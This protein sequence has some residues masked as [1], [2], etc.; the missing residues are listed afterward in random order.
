MKQTL[1]DKLQLCRSVLEARTIT[2]DEPGTILRDVEIVLEVIGEGVQVGGKNAN[3]PPAMLPHLNQRMA[4]PIELKLRRA[5]LR[6]YPNVAGVYILLRTLGLVVPE[7]KKVRVDPERLSTWNAMNPVEKYFSLLEC[8][9]IYAQAG[10]LGGEVSRDSDNQLMKHVPTILLAPLKTWK[11]TFRVGNAGWRLRLEDAWSFQLMARFGL[12]VTR[13]DRGE[14]QEPSSRGWFP[15]EMKATEWG[16]AVA[17]RLIQNTLEIL[18]EAD[19]IV[20]G[21]HLAMGLDESA[22]ERVVERAF[23][24]FFPDLR[25]WLRPPSVHFCEGRY[26]FKI[27]LRGHDQLMR[28]M[29]FD[30]DCSL[31]WVAQEILEEFK[32]ECDHAYHFSYRDKMGRSCRIL[33]PECEEGISA[34]EIGVGDMDVKVGTDIEFLFDFGQRWRFNLRLEKILP[35]ET[36]AEPCVILEGVGEP[37]PQYPDLDN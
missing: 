2:N 10:I 8:W 29:V 32:F 27:T 9:L 14:I 7:K 37:P 15:G 25:S 24:P 36:K 31:D 26:V 1:K 17:S 5:L 22:Q 34:A 20:V 16:Q 4:D 11:S 12:I 23:Q 21:V 35:P 19:E 3:L 28:R 18:P 13:G 33:T 6:D 30:A